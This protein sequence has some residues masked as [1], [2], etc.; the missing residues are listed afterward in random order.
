MPAWLTVI[1]IILAVL[2]VVLGVLMF[3]GNKLRKKQEA[4]QVQI[5]ESKQVISMLIIDKKRMKLKEANLPKI[6]V[7]QTPR[8]LRN[9]KLPIVKAKVGPKIMT[10]I[11]DAKIFDQI[12]V[13]A[14]VKAEVSGMYI[15]GIKSVRGGKLVVEPKKK[16]IKRLMGRF[17]KSK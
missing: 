6:V 7:E 4:Q 3:V 15:V 16:G 2:V 8:Y 11:A 10:L 9:S 1:L 17:N 5:D 12:P 13:K 14:E